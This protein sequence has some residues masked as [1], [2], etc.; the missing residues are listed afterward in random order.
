[1]FCK[2]IWNGIYILPYGDIRLCSIGNNSD[3]SLDMNTARDENGVAMNILTHNIKEIVNSKKHLEVRKLNIDDPTAW[4]PHCSCCENRE[5]VTENNV[6]HPNSSRRLYLKQVIKSDD[7]VTESNCAEKASADGNIDWYPSSLDIRFGNLCNQKCIMCSPIYSKLWYEEYTEYYKTNLFGSGTNNKK[8][9]LIKNDNGQWQ[10]P[11]EMEWYEDPRWWPK[12][13]EMM[14]HLK[15]IYVTGGEPMI[16]PSHD[17][18]LDILIEN[19]FAKNIVLEYDTNL[20]VI[21]TKLFQRWKHFNKVLIRVSMD[22]IKEKYN[23]IRFGGSWEKFVENIEKLKRYEAESN[24][25]IKVQAITSCFQIST[26]LN[27]VES[28]EWCNSMGLPFHIRFLDGPDKHATISLPISAKQELID[29][30]SKHNTEK[31]KLIVNYLTEHLHSTRGSIDEIHSFINFMDFLDNSRST[32]WRDTL[33]DI[34]TFLER[35][36]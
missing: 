34:H 8:I 2:T 33:L 7:I 27:I 1:M 15:H 35:H 21:N 29:F 13:K 16:V 12:F 28:E 18:M 36:K 14:P 20:T 30:Y 6:S 23:L 31:S 10:Q 5:M 32:N 4:S 19:D 3:P 26:A 9:S 25:R 24:G 17:T 22:A 11:K